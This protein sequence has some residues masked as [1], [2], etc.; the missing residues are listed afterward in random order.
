MN[1]IQEILTAPETVS[2]VPKT[3]KRLFPGISPKPQRFL[4]LRR[5]YSMRFED[6]MSMAKAL[7]LDGVAYG[8]NVWWVR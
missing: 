3:E 8:E 2:I 4:S 1:R 5:G 7:G 6:A